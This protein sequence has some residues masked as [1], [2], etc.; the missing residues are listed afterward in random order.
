MFLNE[1][2]RGKCGCRRGRPEGDN[3]IVNPTETV[4]NTRTNTKVVKTIHPTEVINVNRT[5][6]RNENFYPV[7]EREVNE[8]VVENYNCGSDINNPRCVRSDSDNNNSNNHH[9]CKCRRKH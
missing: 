8:T 3:V 4:V 5:V 7:T 6:I 2:R 9:R 1:N